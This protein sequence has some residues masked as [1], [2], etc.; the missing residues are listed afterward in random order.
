M[1]T[2]HLQQLNLIGIPSTWF[3]SPAFNRAP[4]PIA[5]NGVRE[6]NRPFF[7]TLDR[8]EASQAPLL[9]MEHM[10]AAF[11]LDE[12]PEPGQA[13]KYR[14]SY[15]RLIRGWFFDSNRPEGAVLKGWAE[16]RFGL[17]PLYHATPIGSFNDPSYYHYIEERMS[18]RFHNNAI[19]SQLD[20]LYEFCQ[21][22]LTRFTE[23]DDR[24]ITLYRG[25]N[26]VGADSQL[27]EKRDRK[28]WII[29]NNSLVSYSID[30][31]RACE[32]G[33]TIMQIEAPFEKIVCFPHLLPGALP[34]SEGEYLVLGG[35][36]E[37]I[38]RDF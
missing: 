11:G 5:I 30:K 19:F 10:R 34:G 20:L 37:T 7:E 38:I 32:F 2:S 36:Y 23:S 26:G 9:F 31:E 14:A 13:R 8:Y 25:T 33:D 3:A 17:R 35:D 4:S 21:Y 12:K 22:Y 27:V 24:C 29:R 6:M 1:T 16:S 28:V 15:L 18:P